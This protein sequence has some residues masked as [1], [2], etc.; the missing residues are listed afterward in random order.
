[1]P[2]RYAYW[3]IL[4]D[5]KPTAF[6]A[7]MQ[8]DLM[9]TFRRLKEKH[10]S[11][12]LMWFQNGKLWST[13]LEAQEAMRARGERGKAGDVRQGGFRDRKRSSPT[14]RPMTARAGD[15]DHRREVTPRD[16][17]PRPK[18]EWKP[19]GSAS[20]SAKLPWTPRADVKGERTA[21]QN[22][23]HSAKP[24]RRP[25][26]HKPE[27]RDR[28]WRPGGDHKDPRQKYK[29][30]KKAKWQRFKKAIRTSWQSKQSKRRDEDG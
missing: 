17:R 12:T 10:P 1:M 24:S 6:R 8:D 29:D 21:R 27:T 22:D 30:A 5:G 16:E 20:P 19:K 2:P 11:T 18:L 28:S 3:T 9:P 14:S 15:R 7:A 26:G 13:R 25:P 23:R 4:I